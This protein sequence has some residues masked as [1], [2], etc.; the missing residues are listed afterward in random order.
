MTY[1]ELEEKIKKHLGS[2]YWSEDWREANS[3]L[4]S[5]DGDDAVAL[6]NRLF[7]VRDRYLLPRAR[8]SSP[9]LGSSAG[10]ERWNGTIDD[11]AMRYNIGV[12]ADHHISSSAIDPHDIATWQVMGRYA[13]GE[14]SFHS[15]QTSINF[16]YDLEESKYWDRLIDE[17][18]RLPDQERA[19]L[20]EKYRFTA[21]KHELIRLPDQERAVYMNNKSLEEYLQSVRQSQGPV[22]SSSTNSRTSLPGTSAAPSQSI[23]CPTSSTDNESQ[24]GELAQTWWMIYTPVAQTQFLVDHL[25]QAGTSAFRHPYIQGRFYA[26][27]SSPSALRQLLPPSHRGSILN[28]IAVPPLEVPA[29][30]HLPPAEVPTMFHC[31]PME[32]PAWYRMKTGPYKRDIAYG[33]ALSEKSK[34]NCNVRRLL[35]IPISQPDGTITTSSEDDALQV[36]NGNPYIR[37]LLLLRRIK[38]R[39]SVST[40]NA[41]AAQFWREGIRMRIF[42]GTWKGQL[43][44]LCSVAL[45]T[46]TAV[47][48]LLLD[49][50]SVDICISHIKQHFSPGDI[51]RVIAEDYQPSLGSSAHR[52]SADQWGHIILVEGNQLTFIDTVSKAEIQISDYLVQ[53]YTP[54]QPV[55]SSVGIV[56][57]AA[58]EPS[59]RIQLGDI[60]EVIHG[61]SI[62]MS[63][64]VTWLDP[65]FAEVTF[66]NVEQNQNVTVPIMWTT[67]SPSPHVVRF[68]KER[69]YDLKAGDQIRV[70]RGELYGTPGEVTIVD[71]VAK[72][73]TFKQSGCEASDIFRENSPQTSPINLASSS[74]IT[75]DAPSDP[76][77][78]HAYLSSS[79]NGSMNPLT[80]AEN[81]CNA[82]DD[83][84]LA[85]RRG[86]HT[87]I[88]MPLRYRQYDDV[89]PQ[90]PPV[91]A[92]LSVS[93]PLESQSS[94][95]MQDVDRNT[96][97][98]TSPNLFDLVRQFFSSSSPL[99][100][101]EQF[102][103][104]DN[105]SS[106]P[107]SKSDMERSC[108]GVIRKSDEENAF[109][110]FPN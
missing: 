68:S 98:R 71:I 35:N 73:L 5:G 30:F 100:D 50:S 28:Y 59:D 91:A 103:T 89:L 1:A 74:H 13:R 92:P 81:G 41:Y 106:M 67:Y 51:I 53:S 78:G 48:E 15:M 79:G 70:V 11:I 65:Q 63:G 32:I 94:P 36:H 56:T 27:V 109:Y 16:E 82:E 31:P 8:A 43:A 55:Q 29:L 108:E 85:L 2:Q 21:C 20:R 3:A 14:I 25:Q 97:F 34:A 23:S 110:P 60:V 93:Q 72:T 105:L 9:R 66:F 38:V 52:G 7:E 47:V 12:N 80:N 95:S 33:Q 62:G 84:S 83:L 10:T 19:M 64:M 96:L 57:Q 4:W 104:L 86:R 42:H 44:R 69:G 17:L 88:A 39:P 24:L 37:R 76:N 90:P 6:A 101:P 40:L 26:E 61:P 18:I 77:P 99:H 45:E 58:G 54:D 87:G 22:P 75:A 46:H 49:S 102:V 107:T